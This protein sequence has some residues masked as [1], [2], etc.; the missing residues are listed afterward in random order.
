[1][2]APK[3]RE[4]S[5][6]THRSNHACYHLN[7]AVFWNHFDRNLVIFH[8]FSIQNE[9][10]FQAYLI[11]AQKQ[12]FKITI[13]EL[14]GWLFTDGAGNCFN[15]FHGWYLEIYLQIILHLQWCY[16]PRKPLQVEKKKFFFETRSHYGGCCRTGALP[17]SISQ[18]LGLQMCNTM[19]RRKLKIS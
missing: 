8:Y 17:V 6:Q 3:M 5:L 11:P 16:I 7:L 15:F 4:V 18:V 12:Y 14:V 10:I 1:M 2:L 9:K 13:Q 19:Y